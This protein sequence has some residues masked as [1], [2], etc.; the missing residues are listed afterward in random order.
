[1]IYAKKIDKNQNEIV[2]KF[3]ELGFSVYIASSVGRGFPDLLVGKNEKTIL[4]EI[5]SSKTAKFTDAQMEFMRKWKGGTV[6]R[7]DSV[8]GVIHLDNMLK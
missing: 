3:R 6:M 7:I 2:A 5:K 1:M 4:V 8:E